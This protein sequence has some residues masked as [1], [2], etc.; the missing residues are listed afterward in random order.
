MVRKL[1]LGVGVVL[2]TRLPAV[3]GYGLSDA[4]IAAEIQARLVCIYGG[5]PM[6]GWG[7]VVEGPN[8]CAFSQNAEGC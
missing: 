3:S 4:W 8:V 5:A 1:S 6:R 7:L 2:G